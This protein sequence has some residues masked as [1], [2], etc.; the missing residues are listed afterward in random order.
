MKKQHKLF[1]E[2][3]IKI[4]LNIYIYIYIGLKYI[5]VRKSIGK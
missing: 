5:Y 1:G 4:S 3:S 2:Y